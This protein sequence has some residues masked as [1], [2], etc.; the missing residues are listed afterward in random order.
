MSGLRK[1]VCIREMIAAHKCFS[2]LAIFLSKPFSLFCRKLRDKYTNNLA[3][4]K[5]LPIYIGGRTGQAVRMHRRKKSFFDPRQSYHRCPRSE[6][7]PR[8][9]RHVLHRLLFVSFVFS[10]SKPEQWN[11]EHVFFLFFSLCDSVIRFSIVYKKNSLSYI[12]L[13]FSR[14][15][16]HSLTHPHALLLAP[17]M[18]RSN[19]RDSHPKC[20]FRKRDAHLSECGTNNL[21][22][23]SSRFLLSLFLTRSLVR[24]LFASSA[25]NHAKIFFF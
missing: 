18:V 8:Q 25:T 21:S 4:S 14:S 3:M 17:A 6:Q 9:T 13:S 19:E 7:P 2:S 1:R 20:A 12:Y 11:N 15:L 5:C 10:S 16:A 22:F 24:S 23:F